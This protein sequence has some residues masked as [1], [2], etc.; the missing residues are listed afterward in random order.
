VREILDAPT[1]R[2]EAVFL[3]LRTS[4]GLRAEAFAA[5]FGGPPRIFW[6][7]EIDRLV[8]GGLLVEENGGDLRLSSRGRLLSDSVFA[9]FV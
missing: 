7:E 5:D 8:S 6:A 3:A 2:G 1:A 4:A 9:C